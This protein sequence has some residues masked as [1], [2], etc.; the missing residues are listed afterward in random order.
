MLT[1]SAL[2][3]RYLYLPV[4]ATN[5]ATGAPVDPTADAVRWAFLPTGTALTSSATWYTGDWA[6]NYARVLV[7]PP[8]GVITFTPGY[9]DWHA[10]VIDNPEQPIITGTIHIT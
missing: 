6:G 5:M 10:H 7:G 2:E 1:L 3:C 9:W 8:T 4:T